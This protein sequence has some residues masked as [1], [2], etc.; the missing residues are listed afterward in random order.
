MKNTERQPEIAIRQAYVLAGGASR[1]MGRDKLFVTVDGQPLLEHTLAACHSVFENVAL[2]AKSS[3][4]FS[5]FSLPVIIDYPNALGPL[6]GVI[7]AL[8]NCQDE[9][10][11]VVAADLADIDTS[12][13]KAL[14]A[15]YSGEDYLGLLE[16][17]NIQPLCGIYSKHTLET[18][19]AVAKE[20]RPYRLWEI[21][22][23]LNSRFLPVKKTI[24]RNINTP[25]D[26]QTQVG[27]EDVSL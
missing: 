16:A 11:F 1:R 15:N 18:F 3:E 17:G 10:C 24:W 8:A 6:G 4:K 21:V 27:R 13:I 25:D 23:E 7:A 22:K 9:A 12:T 20:N 2:V 19:I 5:D 26:I 14:C